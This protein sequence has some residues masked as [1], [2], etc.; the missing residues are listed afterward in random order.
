MVPGHVDFRNLFTSL[1]GQSY[2]TLA[3]NAAPAPVIA[4]GV[5]LNTA[6]N[7]VIVGFVIF[8]A[9]WTASKL[10]GAPAATAPTMNDWTYC[11][12]AIPIAVT[13]DP[14]RTSQLSKGQ[15]A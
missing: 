11:F 2:L 3:A 10:H 13:R 12:T 7:F 4:Y 6:I 14:H 9:V 1:N 15:S 5:F 8:M